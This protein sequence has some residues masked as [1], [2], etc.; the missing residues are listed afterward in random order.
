VRRIAHPGDALNTRAAGEITRLL[1]GW[2]SGD[3]AAATALLPRVYDRLRRIAGSHLRRERSG[4]TLQ[5]TALVHEVY[6]RLSR[7]RRT[8]WRSRGHFF[9]LAARLMRRVL[10]DHARRRSAARRGGTS[11][12][13]S[14]DELTSP[15]AVPVPASTRRPTVLALAWALDALEAVD[16]E[17]ARVVE[18][19]FFHGMTVAETA[20]E[21]GLAPRTVDR[22]WRVARAWLYREIGGARQAP[23]GR[24]A[25]H[26]AA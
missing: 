4:H 7:Q 17:S 14:F 21:T 18:L 24:D 5:A 1:A 10:V 19:R 8:A 13:R 11:P 6:L 3:G 20:A 12:D 2:R 23:V 15:N 26:A 16:P 22:R 9:R 25:V